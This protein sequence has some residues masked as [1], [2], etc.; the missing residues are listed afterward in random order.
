VEAVL[1]CPEHGTISE[2]TFCH[3]FIFTNGV[4]ESVGSSWLLG[5]GCTIKDCFLGEQLGGW[6]SDSTVEAGPDGGFYRRQAI[7]DDKGQVVLQW[8]V[9][10]DEPSD[11]APEMKEDD[12]S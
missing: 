8:H 2:I 6:E 12:D 11:V 3:H 4:R 10:D 5:C 1:D 7:L 9:N